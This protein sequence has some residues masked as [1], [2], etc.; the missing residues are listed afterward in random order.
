MVPVSVR[1]P[2]ERGA[3]N[4]QVSAMFADLPVGIADPVERLD[5]SAP[6]WTGSS[7]SSRPWPATSLTSLTGFA[8]PMLL[9]LGAAGSTRIPQSQPST[10]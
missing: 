1:L 9:A 10:P 5:S 3:Y 2:G 7:E 4:N 6:R 8:P